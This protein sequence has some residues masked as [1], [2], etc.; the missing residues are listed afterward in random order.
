MVLGSPSGVWRGPVLQV[1][2]SH[3]LIYMLPLEDLL[4][5]GPKEQAGPFSFL[6]REVSRYR[7]LSAESDRELMAKQKQ[8]E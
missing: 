2:G 7:P 8:L 3:K 5:V 1:Q 4:R 6:P